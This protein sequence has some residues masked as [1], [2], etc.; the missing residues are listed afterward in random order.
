MTAT[1]RWP[2]WIRRLVCKL[3]G[4]H[5]VGGAIYQPGL[6]RVGTGCDRCG[7]GFVREYRVQAPLPRF[8]QENNDG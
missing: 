7:E 4:H 6:T 3:R 5:L 8:D 2:A 1:S